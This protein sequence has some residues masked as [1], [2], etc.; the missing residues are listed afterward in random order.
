[1]AKQKKN[2]SSSSK[3][4]VTL[5]YKFFAF[6]GLV[7]AGA[8]ILLGGIFG[9]LGLGVITQVFNIIGAV[10]IGV[11]IIPASWHY[12]AH[13]NIAWK[14]IWIVCLLAYIVGYVLSQI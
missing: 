9:K 8:A 13:K 12:V 3:K 5:D 1:M 6:W 10:A 11:A 2:T 7:F 14:I 4:S